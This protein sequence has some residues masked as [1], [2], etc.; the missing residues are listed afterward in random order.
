MTLA[1]KRALVTGGG[2]GAGAAMTRALACAGAQVV[3]CG[4][5]PAPLDQLASES[6][7]IAAVPCDV[8]DE[9]AVAA[10]F[11]DHGPFDIVVA[12]AGISGA[13]P[14][15]K[16]E[17]DEIE[18]M[19]S[20]NVMGSFFTMREAA[21]SMT[22]GGR[23]VAV[24]STA[25]LKGYAYASAYAAS[26]HAVLGLVRS[27]ALELAGKGIT[28]NAL[29]PGF[30]DTDMTEQSIANIA[31]KTG[32]SAEDARKALAASNPMNTLIDPKSV[33]QALLWLCDPASNSVTGQA[34]ALSG[35]E[36]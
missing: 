31:G 8:T 21:R 22:H 11:A 23:I 2:T 27:I 10:L 24:A 30:M 12:N 16:T 3:I 6:D 7:A 5:R 19:L 29:C 1:G 32:R 28:V 18:R 36:I 26:K 34:I 13:A 25:A 20:V 9:A 4:R 33:A 15:G 14:I 35:G 17:A